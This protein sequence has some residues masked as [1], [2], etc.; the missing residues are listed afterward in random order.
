MMPVAMSV[1][2]IPVVV[3]VPIV[4]VI[5]IMFTVPILRD[6]KSRR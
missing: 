6:R 5:A 2:A 1:I 4:I 3:F